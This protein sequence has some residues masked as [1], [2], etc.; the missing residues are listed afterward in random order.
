MTHWKMSC[1]LP[2]H[3]HSVLPYPCSAHASFGLYCPHQCIPDFSF[4]L[5]S[6]PLHV[7]NRTFLLHCSARFV[8]S[9]PF[10]RLR[11]GSSV[12]ALFISCHRF[13]PWR[14]AFLQSV[15]GGDK[16][17]SGRLYSCG[18]KFVLLFSSP[19]PSIRKKKKVHIGCHKCVDLLQEKK[20][21]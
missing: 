8:L 7:P 11:M 1:V 14:M 10:P 17:I 5:L 2:S 12:L 20:H 15:L 13:E 3:Y 9:P 21:V 18:Q 16:N 6:L 19:E 4:P